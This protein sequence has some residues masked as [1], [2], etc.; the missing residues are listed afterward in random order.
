M[1]EYHDSE[2][3]QAWQPVWILKQNLKADFHTV[4]QYK[5]QTKSGLTKHL[6]SFFRKDIT[7]APEL[8]EFGDEKKVPMVLVSEHIGIEKLSKAGVVYLSVCKDRIS[9]PRT[10]GKKTSSSGPGTARSWE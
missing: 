5:Q 1:T 10:D 3:V 9:K 8:D 4:K 2:F 6:V 7:Q